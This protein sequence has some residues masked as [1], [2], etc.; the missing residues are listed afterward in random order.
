MKSK[1]ELKQIKEEFENLNKKIAEL[2]EEELAW[3]C[4]GQLIAD[5]ESSKAGD[6]GAQ[7]FQ[8][9]TTLAQKFSLL[10]NE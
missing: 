1:E 8:Q 10:G 2:T 5:I 4:G 7:L 3:V 6:S 9:N